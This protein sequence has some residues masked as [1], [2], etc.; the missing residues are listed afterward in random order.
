M[1]DVWKQ[2]AFLLAEAVERQIGRAR[3]LGSSAPLVGIVASAGAE[4]ADIEVERMVRQYFMAARK[5]F[6]P[7]NRL[8]FACDYSRVS[9]RPTCNG[10]VTS[11]NLAAWAPPQVV[12]T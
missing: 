8:G 12:G 1:R 9:R 6:G 4:L 2:V 5:A 3:S 7:S 11:G 10:I